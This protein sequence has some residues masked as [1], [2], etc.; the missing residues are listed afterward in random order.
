MGVT[1]DVDRLYPGM[2]FKRLD[3]SGQDLSELPE[4]LTVRGDLVIEGTRIR[5]LPKG[6]K[7]T[8]RLKAS[9]SEL[10]EIDLDH[11]VAGGMDLSRTRIEALPD[12]LRVYGDLNVSGTRLRQLP[13]QLVV[14]GSIMMRACRVAIVP[15]DVVVGKSVDLRGGRLNALPAA[16]RHVGGSLIWEDMGRVTVP[17][18]LAVEGNL[19]MRGTVMEPGWRRIE[20]GGRCYHSPG[21]RPRGEGD[22]AVH[23]SSFIAGSGERIR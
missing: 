20:V 15:D 7:V 6:L 11:G 4:D 22:L 9:G 10:E 17:E 13:R 2:W 14:T 23:G 12:G 5:R 21:D 1:H 16:F 8:G 3:L 19:E 18:V